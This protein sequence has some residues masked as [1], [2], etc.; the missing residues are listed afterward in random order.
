M[1]ANLLLR[2][3][4]PPAI[5]GPGAKAGFVRLVMTP[6]RT[7]AL[8]AEVA[9]K[10]GCVSIDAEEIVLEPFSAA[11]KAY[12]DWQKRY[13]SVNPRRVRTRWTPW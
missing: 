6:G 1:S 4:V 10:A 11:D 8:A 7:F 9:G 13:S 2:E 3:A 5:E 12:R